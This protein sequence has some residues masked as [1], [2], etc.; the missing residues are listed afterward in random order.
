[1]SSI[2]DLAQPKINK[3]N[4]KYKLPSGRERFQAEA[5]L[6]EGLLKGRWAPEAPSGALEAEPLQ[7]KPAPPLLGPAGLP[8]LVRWAPIVVISFTCLSRTW[9]QEV[10]EPESG[11]ED[12]GPA[13]P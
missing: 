2:E 6:P 8:R 7:E 3:T 1:M 9:G 12:L 4:K 13:G 5:L 11:G 10:M